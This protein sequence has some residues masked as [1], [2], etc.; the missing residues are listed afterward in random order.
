MV[1][2][3]QAQHGGERFVQQKQRIGIQGVDALAQSR[4]IQHAHLFRA[5]AGLGAEAGQGN[6]QGPNRLG[7]GGGE[8]IDTG[9]HHPPDQ[10]I[11]H[12]AGRAAQQQSSLPLAAGGRRKAREPPLSAYSAPVTGSTRPRHLL[13]L[14][15]S[16]NNSTANISP[17]AR[18]VVE[19][20][21]KAIAQ[22]LTSELNDL[23]AESQDHAAWLDAVKDLQKRLG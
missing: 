9:Q 19:L 16:R 14:T 22:I 17:A 20:A 15:A 1:W 3:V 23:W 6:Q 18:G 5:S 8:R 12:P 4:F 7:R 11:G 13:A 21:R 10:G 2:L